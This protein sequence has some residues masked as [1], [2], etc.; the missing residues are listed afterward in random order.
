MLVV[1]DGDVGATEFTRAD[2]ADT[3]TFV[4]AI[5]TEVVEPVGAGDAFA[6]GHLAAMMDGADAPGRLTAGH[7][8]AHLVLLS[9]SDFV[10]EPLH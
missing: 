1:K 2:G 10:D 6:A 9:T 5:P 4:A 3:G 7:A 8:R